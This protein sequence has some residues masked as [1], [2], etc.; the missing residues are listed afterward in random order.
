MAEGRSRA[1]DGFGIAG[2]VLFLGALLAVILFVVGAWRA[3][4]R[5]VIPVLV[6]LPGGSWAA[7]GVLGIV[8][9]LGWAGAGVVFGFGGAKKAGEARLVRA[10]RGMGTAVCWAAAVG[11]VFLLFVG[12]GG[13]NCRSSAC[14]YI[15]GTGSA[16]LSYAVTATVLGLFC[17]RWRR[18]VIEA[19]EAVERERRRKLRKKGK[20]RAVRDGKG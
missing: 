4:A 9:V 19:R 11:P 3:L 10:A 12:L 8:S 20:S 15:P 14:E 16:F 17:Y 6:E 1:R 13:K 7:G 2:G 5:E 18:G